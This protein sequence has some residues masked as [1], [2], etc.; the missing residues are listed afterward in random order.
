MADK[1]T[2]R[3]HKWRE[4]LEK[5]TVEVGRA[6]AQVRR[7]D[8]I[9]IG[10]GCGEPQTLV[11]AL[12]ETSGRLADTEVYHLLTLG[13]APY[14]DSRFGETFRLNSFFIG[15]D[16]R[17]DVAEGRADYTPVYLS[18]VPRLFRTGQ[19]PLDVALIQV[20]PPDEHGYCSFGVAVDITK[21]ATEAARLVIAQMNPR[22]PR[23]L[24][25]SFI[26]VDELDSV[27][28]AEEPLLSGR[29]PL[30]DDVSLEVGRQAAKLVDHGACLQIGI[31][32]APP[33]VFRFLHDR[34]DLGIHTEMLTAEVIELVNEG[35][36][37]N[38]R[39]SIHRG[40]LVASFCMGGEELYEFVDNNPACEFHPSDY[41]NDPYVIGQN[42]NMVAINA[43]LEIDLTGQVCSDSLGYNFYSGIG[44]Q[45]DFIRG[46]SRSRGGKPVICLPSTRP[47]GESRIVPVLSEGAGVVTTRGSVHYVVTEYGVAY[48]HGKSIRERALSLIQIAHPDHRAELLAHAKERRYV[49]L[50]QEIP[51]GTRYPD[52]LERYVSLPD[53]AQVLIRPLKPTDDSLLRDLFYDTSEQSLY[54]R[55]MNTKTTLPRKERQGVLNI[56]YHRN[57]S[58]AAQQ[59]SGPDQLVGLAE[60]SLDPETNLAEVAFL[61]RDDWQN[62]G[63]GKRLMEYMIELAMQRGIAGFT[64]EILAE[65]R[66]MLN[67]FHQC[68]RPVKTRLTDGC[69]SV[70]VEF[71][72]EEVGRRQELAAKRPSAPLGP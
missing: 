57:M 11:R 44:G 71:D 37:T 18:E 48:L 56:D 62:R 36:I 38:A 69:Y 51:A 24:G 49:F 1:R 5:K 32:H 16:V 14:T 19:L 33:T 34:K 25:D 47:D 30:P 41:T 29:S 20:T 27:V 59:V 23:T 9:F 3:Q 8:H 68:A 43:A 50:D 10:A 55:Y 21:P 6:L 42:E 39:K 28:W 31:G 40:K 54:H 13:T 17:K 7:G 58:L 70:M 52:E 15:A 72:R 53:T 66:V 35:V 4:R 67:L 26:H 12:T 65:N 60:W 2:S 63:L 46:A 64:A 45:V 61:V 22:M